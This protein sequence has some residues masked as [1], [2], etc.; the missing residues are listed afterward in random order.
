M[1]GIYVQIK[2]YTSQISVYVYANLSRLLNI[3]VIPTQSL[4]HVHDFSSSYNI[5]YS[6]FQSVGFIHYVIVGISND[7]SNWAQTGKSPCQVSGETRNKAYSAIKWY[8]WRVKFKS[9]TGYFSHCL[10]AK[11]RSKMTKGEA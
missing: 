9:K 1:L 2:R 8:S 10:Q 4:M 5:W 3:S 6:L 7:A 11:R